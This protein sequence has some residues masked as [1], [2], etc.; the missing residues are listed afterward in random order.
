M[1][2]NGFTVSKGILS[3]HRTLRGGK[4]PNIWLT[5]VLLSEENQEITIQQLTNF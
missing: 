2:N 4:N 5:N 3:G 1:E